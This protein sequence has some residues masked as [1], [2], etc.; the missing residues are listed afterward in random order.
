M[1]KAGSVW[2][3]EL[4]TYCLCGALERDTASPLQLFL[5]EMCEF[6]LF[7]EN[8][9]QSQAERHN[10]PEFIKSTAVMKTGKKHYRPETR[11]TR[12]T[13]CNR[14][15]G[16]N[17]KV[18]KSDQVCSLELYRCLFP[19]LIIVLWFVGYY[20]WKM[21]ESHRKFLCSIFHSSSENIKLFPS[22][23]NYKQ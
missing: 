5:M 14:P 18:V 10:L 20:L 19:S 7:E 4:I 6:N 3:T 17:W 1:A 11:E 21:E 9:R 12:T 23:Q 16:Q 2:V 8:L 15:E 22:P 13:R